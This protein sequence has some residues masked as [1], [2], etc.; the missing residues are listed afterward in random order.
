MASADSL[1]YSLTQG[2]LR[3]DD[4]VASAQMS[5]LDASSFG[6]LL[7]I[8]GSCIDALPL[9]LAA[10]LRVQ[11]VVDAAV[12]A[13]FASKVGARVPSTLLL[14]ATALLSGALRRLMCVQWPRAPIGLGFCPR[15][16]VR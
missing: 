6:R 12:M 7:R 1:I 13:S 2:E 4:V 10:A 3:D 9:K 11:G 15:R 8:I 14:A 16:L 5:P